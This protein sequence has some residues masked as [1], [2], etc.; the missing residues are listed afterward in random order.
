M[1]GLCGLR[2]SPDLAAQPIAGV[3]GICRPTGLALRVKILCNRRLEFHWGSRGRVARD[4]TLAES[5]R[6]G[7]QTCSARIL[8]EVELDDGSALCDA[9]DTL[10]LAEAV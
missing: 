3:A 2:S 5:T 1:P 6:L 10:E 7:A 9:R 4:V 8:A